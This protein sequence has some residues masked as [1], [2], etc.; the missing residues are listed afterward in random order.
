MH[1]NSCNGYNS[2]IW[3]Q[4]MK[5]D[6]EINTKP[7]KEFKWSITSEKLIISN[8]HHNVSGINR[9]CSET[10]NIICFVWRKFPQKNRG[11]HYQFPLELKLIQDQK[12]NWV[13]LLI[14]FEKEKTFIK[15]IQ[16]ELFHFILKACLPPFKKKTANV[17][18]SKIIHLTSQTIGT[19]W[20]ILHAK[21]KEQNLINLFFRL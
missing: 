8:K 3:F 13:L 14:Y 6:I 17:V 5:M 19:S 15:K 18:F 21:Q 4:K 20:G 11:K 9:L 10:I 7:K 16:V 12:I 1:F 2:K